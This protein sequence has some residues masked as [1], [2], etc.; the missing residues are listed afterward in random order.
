MRC[1]LTLQAQTRSMMLNLLVGYLAPRYCDLV[2]PNAPRV[3]SI[4]A[5]LTA[6]TV[7]PAANSGQRSN[8]SN[9]SNIW[10][11]SST[12]KNGRN[13]RNSST[14]TST[15]HH[16]LTNLGVLSSWNVEQ[17]R[18]RLGTG[19]PTHDIMSQSVDHTINGSGV[20]DTPAM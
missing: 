15:D 6:S 9:D 10:N 18:R 12:T 7:G 8:V 2:Y 3:I 19:R 11:S 1:V 14:R 4:P 17:R 5:E 13:S 16:Q 20:V